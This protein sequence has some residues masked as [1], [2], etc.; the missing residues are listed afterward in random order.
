[1][2]DFLRV[3][4]GWARVGCVVNVPGHALRIRAHTR[5][6][7]RTPNVRGSRCRCWVPTCAVLCGASLA[8]VTAR[9]P[10][11]C[12]EFRRLS[13]A[14]RL[15]ECSPAVYTVFPHAQTSLTRKEKHTLW[16]TVHV[17]MSFLLFAAQSTRT[18][19]RVDGTGRQ[20]ASSERTSLY[21]C[22][23]EKN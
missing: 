9:V 14:V 8:F 6:N 2:C 3:E 7:V 5:L 19:R 21:A 23:G 22:Q 13:H 20:T 11:Q 15:Q 1:M 12:W 18:K 10:M 4:D 16:V 17:R